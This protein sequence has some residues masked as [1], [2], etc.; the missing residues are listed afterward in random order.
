MKFEQL[1]PHQTPLDD[2]QA[3]NFYSCK[4]E[5]KAWKDI[6][7]FVIKSPELGRCQM[8]DA[9][10]R[11]I[12]VRIGQYMCSEECD[13]QFWNAHSKKLLEHVKHEERELEVAN[14]AK[15]AWKDIIIV[16][17]NELPYLKQCIASLR[18]HTKNCTVYIWNNNSDEET[19]RY[20]DGLM[21]TIEP[22]VFEYE[23]RHN[24]ENIGFIEPN[25]TFAA[26]GNG[27]YIILLNSDCMVFENWDKAMLGHLQEDPDLAEVG[28]LGGALDAEGKGIRSGRYGYDIDFV[29][30]FA[31]CVSRDTYNQFGLFNKQLRF[32]YGEDSDLSLRLKAAG[33]KILA[34]YTNLVFH[35]GNKT[36]NKVSKQGTVIA[37]KETFEANHRYIKTKWRHY[38]ENDRVL[39]DKTSTT[40]RGTDASIS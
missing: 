13:F 34:L 6:P 23:I 25:N 7:N 39:L 1:Y 22:G 4:Q 28:Y 26:L 21:D 27:D 18:R 29:C 16:V 36:V 12:D 10:T 33:K 37:L 3:S 17:H 32:A 24:P 30:G 11:W 15:D 19:A 20:L 8:C 5:K 14:R 38:L 35:H 2:Q 40:W 31:L 9:Y